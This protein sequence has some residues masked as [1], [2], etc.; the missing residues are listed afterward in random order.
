MWESVLILWDWA[1]ECKIG[2]VSWIEGGK[3]NSGKG[4]LNFQRQG[5]EGASLGSGGGRTNV[6]F[7]LQILQD[8]SGGQDF[9]WTG[10]VS[11]LQQIL[12]KFLSEAR[13]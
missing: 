11:L 12:V 6:L 8:Y 10:I 4:R 7:P 2:H 13:G 1:E 3:K 9:T 5:K